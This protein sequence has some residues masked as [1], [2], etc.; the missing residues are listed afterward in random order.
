MG[1]LEVF[2]KAETNPNYIH[3]EIT[4]ILNVSP[5]GKNFV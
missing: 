1:K 5:V 3:E 2:G 4:R